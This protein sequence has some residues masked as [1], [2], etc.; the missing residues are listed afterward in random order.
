MSVNSLV[1]SLKVLMCGEDIFMVDLTIIVLHLDVTVVR[2]WS[3]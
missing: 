2:S 3:V 1:L